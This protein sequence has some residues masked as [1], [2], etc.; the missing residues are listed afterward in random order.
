[1]N[2]KNLMVF[3]LAIVG[4]LFVVST[5]S[6]ADPLASINSV[7]FDGVY[8][9]YT[10]TAGDSVSVEVRFNALENAEDVRVKAELEGKDIDVEAKTSKF[11]VEADGN[12]KKTLVLDIP[13]D[14]EDK[15]SEDATL[16]ITIENGDFETEAEYDV[17]IQRPSYEADVKMISVDSEVNAGDK[18]SVDLTLKNTGYGDLD[19]LY[20]T[21]GIPALG[22]SRTAY[23]GDLIA[24]ECD[25]DAT[26]LKNYGVDIDR[27][28]DEDDEDTLRGVVYLS[29]PYEAMSGLYTL[30]VTVEN[31]DMSD[32]SAKQI[33][34]NNDF[35]A[36]NVIVA[37]AAK[38]G[39]VGADVTYSLHIA[40]PTDSLKFYRVV[41]ESTGDVSTKVDSAVVGVPAGTSKVVTV[42]ANAGSAGE[43]TF[44]VNVLEGEK[45]VSATQLSLATDGSKITS[46][47]NPVVVLTVVLA[48][49][50]VVL[51]IVLIVLLGKKPEK[52]EDFGESYY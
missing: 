34:I 8:T 15:L 18:V 52:T 43:H 20:V 45:L 14:V 36:G 12:Y 31:D 35:S 40:N 47:S 17:R 48:I 16:T 6:A 3:F 11:V 30:E 28:C 9:A 42:T 26:A 38:T 49:I 51:L 46:V 22:V 19:D 25:E 33:F 50:F 7:K 13:N 21:V 1:M 10:A 4:A 41:P 23:L 39:A 44:N 2:T 5:V 29:V 27:K 24:V 37:S 32:T